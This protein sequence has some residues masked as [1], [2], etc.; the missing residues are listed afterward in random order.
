[1][2]NESDL[3][4]RILDVGRLEVAI[5][6]IQ[7][8]S[9]DDYALARKNYFGASDSSIL[10]GVNLYKTLDELLKEKNNKFIT[11]E[12][13]EVGEKPIVK[14][15]YDLEPI[16]LDKAEQELERLGHLGFL[17]KPR[18]MFKFKDVDGLS[19]NYDGVFVE[20]NRPLVPVEAKL[21][22]KYGEKYYNKQVTHEQAKAL[23]M[24]VEGTNLEQHIKRKA[25][26]L[27][28]PPYYY[29]QVQQEINGLDAP[30]GYLAAMFDD[31]WTFKLFYIPR[32]TYVIAAIENKCIENIT[33]IERDTK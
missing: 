28:V 15:G 29:T 25:L 20:G 18:D 19:V 1:M 14:K 13:R 24:K 2:I 22:S 12:E 21:V 8:M 11:D 7:A 32:D 5:D 17:F 9:H 30:Y 3:T 33:K 10:C 27:G 4:Q 16:I 6:N 31:S 23:D 26:K